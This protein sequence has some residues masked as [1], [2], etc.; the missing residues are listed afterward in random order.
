MDLNG[1]VA[2]RPTRGRVVMVVDNGVHGDSRVQK[3]ARSAAE[4]G[5]DVILIGMKGDSEVESWR[6]G[7]AEVRLVP[8]A[9]QL[10]EPA[11]RRGG[12]LRRPFAYADGR[13]VGRRQ[14]LMKAWR[15][16]I[17]A[18]IAQQ[19]AERG[20]AGGRGLPRLIVPRAGLALA[21]RWVRFRA[22]QTRK[23]REARVQPDQWLN[24]MTV[25]YWTATMGARSWRRLDPSLWEWELAFGKVIDNLKPDIIHAHDFKMVGVGA[26]AA[27]R[28]RA[29]G[30]DVRFVFD[31]HEY[32]PGLLPRTPGWLEA[33]V[34]YEREYI[35]QADAVVTVSDAL[36]DLL[37][38][39][40]RLAEKPTVV[41]NSPVL[42]TAEAADDDTPVRDLRAL[43]GLGPD[44]PLLAYSG[45]ITVVRGVDLV[46]EALTHLPDVHL[47]MLSVAPSGIVS[48]AAAKLR[49]QAVALGVA[50]RVH[51]LPYVPHW[52]VSRVLAS[53]DAAVSPLHHLPN[54]EIA[55]SNKFFEY[56]HARLPLIVS[57]VKTMADMVRSTGQG[58]VFRAK[59]LAD[60]LRAAKLVLADPDK[61]RAAY[62]RPGLLEQWSWEAQAATL[63]QLYARLLPHAP[64]APAPHDVDRAVDTGSGQP[65]PAAGPGIVVPVAQP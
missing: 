12:S 62:D 56:S 57:D 25:R 29:R 47:A 24:R 17:V 40:H 34:A 1:V 9:K 39:D 64:A 55:L 38:T 7:D 13:H 2:A 50:D 19:R 54:H 6:L 41:M 11:F 36:A 23:L 28:A 45:G 20:K 37:R 35:R 22:G 32:V 65:D 42:S 49:E 46:V 59:D 26:R 18:R 48:R 43:C 51:L 4:A 33:Q 61:Y 30:R 52:Q 53:A 3:S 16:D 58:E 10:A 15:A 8:V 21:S 63:D 5:W 31:A 27:A 14:Q 44:T 60:F